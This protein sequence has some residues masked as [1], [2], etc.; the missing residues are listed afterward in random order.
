MKTILPL[1]SPKSVLARLH[2][3]SEGAAVI[4]AAFILPVI[5]MLLMGI[6]TYGR[7]FMAAHSLQ[8]AANDAARAAVAGLDDTDRG[9]IVDNSIDNSA[10]NEGTLERDLVTVAKARSTTYYTVTLTYDVAKSNL[11][12]TAMVPLPGGP[13]VRKSTVKLFSL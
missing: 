8:Q 2:G 5:I 13:L 3:S 7:W 12:E 4:E 9:K 10:L 6:L 1:R 11:G